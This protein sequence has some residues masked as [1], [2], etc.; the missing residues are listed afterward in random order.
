MA[1][2]PHPPVFGECGNAVTIA[3]KALDLV[4]SPKLTGGAG[5]HSSEFVHLLEW[6]I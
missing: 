2:A 4:L 3:P 5:A 6:R 1:G